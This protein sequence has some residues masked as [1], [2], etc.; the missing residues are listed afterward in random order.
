M[1][2]HTLYKKLSV[3]LL[4]INILTFIQN[5]ILT[6][7]LPITMIFA[8]I[9][10]C[11]CGIWSF[12]EQPRSPWLYGALSFLMAIYHYLANMSGEFYPIFLIINILSCIIL[13]GV[14]LADPLRD[15]VHRIYPYRISR[16]KEPEYF[17]RFLLIVTCIIYL[18]IYLALTSDGFGTIAT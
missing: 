6:A 1:N 2:Q 17:A 10:I 12:H 15:P 4:I 13:F 8:L 18:L 14:A 11:I 16:N 5:C 3:I 7:S 9:F